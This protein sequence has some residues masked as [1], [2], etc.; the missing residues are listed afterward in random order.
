MEIPAPPG[1]SGLVPMDRDK[2]RG[3]AVDPAA[4]RSFRQGLGAAYVSLPEF[5]HAARDYPIAFARDA[6]TGGYVPVAV[7]GVTGERNL[8]V[9]EDGAWEPM[10]YVPAYVRRWPFFAVDVRTEEGGEPRSIICVDDSALSESDEP[11]L[12]PESGTSAAW[13]QVESLVSEMQGAREPTVRMSETLDRLELMIPFEA[14]AHAKSGEQFRLKGLFR[15]SEEK[16]S[17]VSAGELKKM[18]KR[19]ELPRIYA[20]LMSLDNFRF[21]LD[22][23]VKAGVAEPADAGKD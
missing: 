21:L 2:H 10:R 8:F 11:L 20:H 18:M 1:Y 13:T 6:A 15:V 23:A 4:R 5:Q 14:H 12:D 7:L 3:L 16:L 19:G 17:E 9:D 22:R